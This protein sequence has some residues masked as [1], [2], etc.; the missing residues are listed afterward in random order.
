MQKIQEAVDAV[1]SAMRLR[2]CSE[3]TLEHLMWSV[4]KPIVNYHHENGT[5]RCSSNLL[6]GI[7]DR[8]FKRYRNGAISR[9]Y[10]RAFVTAAFRIS[11]YVATGEIDFSIVKDTKKYNPAEEFQVIVNSILE[12]SGLKANHQRKLGITMRHFFCFFEKRHG[13][14]REVT[15]TDFLEFIPEAAKNNPCNMN[16]TIRALRYIAKYLN[17]QQLSKISID[18]SLFCPQ[19]PPKRMIAPFTQDDIVAM[20]NVIGFHS[21]TPKRDIAIILLA[22]NSGLRGVDIRHL[23]RSNINWKKQE[24]RIVQKKTGEP[25]LVPLKGK[26]LNAVAEYI[27][28]ERPKCDDAHVF[29]RAYP[30]YTEIK[31]TSPLDYMLDKYCRIASIA[32]VGY[33]SFHDSADV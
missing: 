27:L 20:V 14:I 2:K 25:L 30:P 24:L 19:S 1:F 11:S 15:D 13:S 18:L 7:C 5:E 17:D 9:K 23:K 6:N 26:T 12:A 8:Q 33:R 32:K 4:Y 29:L 16:S 28:E 3:S 31:S 22:F 21:K 10:Y